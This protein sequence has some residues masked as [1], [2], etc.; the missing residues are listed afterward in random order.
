M[1]IFIH[2]E[3]SIT[4]CK[5]VSKHLYLFSNYPARLIKSTISKACKTLGTIEVTS[6]VGNVDINVYEAYNQMNPTSFPHNKNDIGR[7]P[8]LIKTKKKYLAVPFHPK[9]NSSF[10]NIIKKLNINNVSIASRTIIKNRTHIYT[11]TKD[12]RDLSGIKNAWFM[13]KCQN[14][15]FECGCH[16]N[17]LDVERTALHHQNNES[18]TPC[19]HINDHES[20]K[21]FVDESTVKTFKNEKELKLFVK[22]SLLKNKECS[23]YIT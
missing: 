18:S 10:R 7:N 8:S 15:S 21:L 23:K 19:K 12:K 11:N 13:I 5:I 9:L 4:R 6:S 14:C 2:F 1:E 3:S 16:T 20:H 17:N 22:K